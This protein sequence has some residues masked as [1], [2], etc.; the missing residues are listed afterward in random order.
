M[1]CA[2]RTGARCLP[3][4]FLC[5]SDVS[6]TSSLFGSSK[7]I[8]VVKLLPEVRCHFKYVRKN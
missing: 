3:L 8:I 5:V 6:H 2:R 4:L 7:R 1:R